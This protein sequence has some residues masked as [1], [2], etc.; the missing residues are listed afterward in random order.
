MKA[1]TASPPKAEYTTAT[2][3]TRYE[4]RLRR[5][6]CGRSPYTN[7]GLEASE[8]RWWPSLSSSRG[9]ES[10]LRPVIGAG[11]L[12]VPPPSPAC[13][14]VPSPI[15]RQRRSTGGASRQCEVTTAEFTRS[16]H[17][18]VE[19]ELDALALSR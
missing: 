17:F 13:T 9:V 7:V 6:A 15:R 11:N 3:S 10:T 16:S 1:R 4:T 12:A 14:C 5:L 19:V 18:V 2:T 8:I